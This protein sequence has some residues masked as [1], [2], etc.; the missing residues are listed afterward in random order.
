MEKFTK[1]TF[2]FSVLTT[3][4][5]AIVGGT[6]WN[7][8]QDQISHGVVK[9]DTWVVAFIVLCFSSIVLMIRY[10]VYQVDDLHRKNRIKIQYYSSSDLNGAER[11]YTESRKLIEQIPEDGTSKIIAVNSFVEIFQESDDPKAEEFRSS[12]FR[13]IEKKLNK[14]DYHRV[15]QLNYS[16]YQS[17][18]NVNQA[19]NDV[20]I[21][22]IAKNYKEHFTN[23]IKFRDSGNFQNEIRLDR[24]NARYPM[25]FIIIE[26]KENTSYLLWQINEHIGTN[27]GL[28]NAFKL[29]GI[30]LIEDP[31]QQVTKHFKAWFNQL[32]NSDTLRPIQ[33]TDLDAKLSK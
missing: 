12:Y 17:I 1:P 29:T 21:N 16:T 27:N 14:I 26:N 18:Q 24:V 31:D 4:I 20:I 19:T 7:V 3:A 30:F 25:A 33:L 8:I 2:L 6:I 23:V 22:R 9:S 5:C 32:T 28:S 11:I 10:V 13:A 15:L